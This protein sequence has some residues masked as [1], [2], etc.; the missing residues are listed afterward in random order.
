MQV[1]VKGR[2]THVSSHMKKLAT[3]KLEKVERFLDR[4]QTCE[5]EFSEEHNPRIADK[6]VVEVTMS[7]K[8]HVLRAHASGPDPAS[9]IDRVLAKLEAQVK[10]LKGRL[11]KRGER[12]DGV[13]PGHTP[14]PARTRSANG[15]GSATAAK[16]AKVASAKMARNGARVPIE[17]ETDSEQGT[18]GG[19]SITRVKRFALKPMTAEEAVLQM[20]TL[21]HDFYLFV[22]AESAQAGVV[23]RRRNGSFGLIEPD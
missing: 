18:A 22:N 3:A 4:I 11:V 10:R 13:A 17:S 15:S 12:T 1:I 23:Y 6:H 14:K 8:Q 21:G 5:V 7:T 19:P 16:A 20:D 9:A 2:N